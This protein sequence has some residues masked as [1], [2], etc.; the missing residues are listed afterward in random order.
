[1][2]KRL[3]TKLEKDPNIDYRGENPS[4]MDNLTDAVFG[5]AVTLLIFN[6]SNPNSLKDLIAFT[7]TLPA[8]LVSIGFL[9]IIWKE[10]SRFSEIY[11]LRGPWFV[12]L[13]SLFIALVIFYVYP[14]RFLTL[15]MT[16][17]IFGTD[18]PVTISP[19]EIPDIMIYYGF[20]AFALYFILLWFYH[21]ALKKKEILQLNEY[22]VMHTKM[23]RKRMILMC[24]VPIASIL[25]V[26]GLR[27][28]SIPLACFLGGMMYS[29]YT[30]A[31]IFWAKGYEKKASE[32]IDE[33][34][35]FV[36]KES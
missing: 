14:L 6:L 11:G 28:V 17:A 25:L 22:E 33:N 13:N 7:K 24:V 23:V 8:F 31:I 4:R 35:D 2:R 27:G 29:L 32:L 36:A 20:V 18:L 26:T 9:I 5:I 34:P 12:F 1:M 10:H 19:Q 16:Q 30:P 15:F 21:L 3:L